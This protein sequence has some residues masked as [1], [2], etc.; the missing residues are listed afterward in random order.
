MSAA[1]IAEL[2]HELPTA[3][4]VKEE[5]AYPAQTVGEHVGRPHLVH[6]LLI[7]DP[8]AEIREALGLQKDEFCVLESSVAAG[9]KQ[10]ERGSRGGSHELATTD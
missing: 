2:V 3:R 7:D 6:R 5:S 9:C 1:L 8:A 10:R 4:F